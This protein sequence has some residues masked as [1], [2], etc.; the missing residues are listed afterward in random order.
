MKKIVNRIINRMVDGRRRYPGQVMTF[1]LI[2]IL[3]LSL[4]GCSSGQEAGEG[5]ETF[6]IGLTQ[7]APHPSLDNI[8]EGFIQGLADAGF[9]EG[10]NITLDITNADGKGENAA[11]IAQ[12]YVAKKTDLITAIATPSAMAAHS[13]ADGSGI[14]VLFSAVS[15]PIFA[16]LVESLE[17][18]NRGAS[19]TADIL[20]LEKQMKMIRAFLPESKKIGILYTTNEVNSQSHL[21]TFEELAPKYG[22]EII[23]L[24]VNSPSDI[25]LAV[26]SLLAQV[27]CVNNF[28]DN[29]VVN[30]LATLIEKAKE[31]GIPVF[32]SE[33]EQV[34]N[35]CIASESIDYYELGRIT[36]TMAV[37]LLRGEDV[38]KM[39]VKLISESKPVANAEV[40]AS[41]GIELPA[42]YLGNIEYLSAK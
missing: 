41:L 15:D 40:M 14:P 18:P 36:A 3:A 12:N 17:I 9:E 6:R 7:Y 29:N 34:R 4:V 16:K 31:K 30:N 11:L 42:E 2:A 26:D 28:T 8:R 27:D 22:F 24:G 32:G 19:G 10:K 33:E 35:G 1:L 38:D 39:P 21:E 37:Q 20:P 25:P 13:A 23:A 5:D